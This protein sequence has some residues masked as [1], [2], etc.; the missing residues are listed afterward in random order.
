MKINVI[1]S[2]KFVVT[3]DV[4]AVKRKVLHVTFSKFDSKFSMVDLLQRLTA[5]VISFNVQAIKKIILEAPY[6]PKLYVL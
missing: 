4:G 2:E 1:P 6:N 5:L 3:I